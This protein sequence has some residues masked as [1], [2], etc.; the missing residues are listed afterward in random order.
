MGSNFNPSSPDGSISA[1]GS[2]YSLPADTPPPAYMPPD[3]E[4]DNDAMDTSGRPPPI[5]TAPRNGGCFLSY[6]LVVP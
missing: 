2:P 5:P 1:P 3:N 6:N 4:K